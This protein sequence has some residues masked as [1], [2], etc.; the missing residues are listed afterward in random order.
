MLGLKLVP[1]S[2]HNFYEVACG[3]DVFKGE[4][5]CGIKH[6]AGKGRLYCPWQLSAPIVFSSRLSEPSRSQWVLNISVGVVTQKCWVQ[7]WDAAEELFLK[8]SAEFREMPNSSNRSRVLCEIQQD[9]TEPLKT[10]WA[11]ADVQFYKLVSQSC[12]DLFWLTW[13][14]FWVVSLA[15][16]RILYTIVSTPLPNM[17]FFKN[18]DIV[19]AFLHRKLFYL[20]KTN[21]S[22]G[23]MVLGEKIFLTKRILK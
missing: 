3:W 13:S 11:I 19:D 8:P 6:H 17:I 22:A 18:V 5:N 21:T 16:F 1:Q 23:I 7:V 9:P 2:R 12:C 4:K 20:N 15:F 14:G 10:R